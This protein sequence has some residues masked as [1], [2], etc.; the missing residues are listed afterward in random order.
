[1]RH[2]V[3]DNIGA[4]MPRGSQTTI[5]WIA[6]CAIAASGCGGVLA[7]AYEYDEMLV[8]ALDGSAVVD[9]NASVASL[10]VLRGIVLDLDEPPDLGRVRAFFETDGVTVSRIETSQRAG[11]TFVHVRVEVDDLPKLSRV[12]ALSWSLYRVTAQDEG[13]SYRQIVGLPSP[14]AKVAATAVGW[15]GDERVAFRLRAPSVVVSHN[16]PSG[17]ARGNIVVWEQPLAVRLRGGTVDMRVELDDQPILGR[18]LTLF[19]TTIAAAG[20][21]FAIAVWWMVSRGRQFNRSR[22]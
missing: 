10:V 19:A 8:L 4:T 3:E 1:M 12:P 22:R 9:V 7:P 11:R 13:V 20:A 16:A 5:W 6:T 17:V 15:S 14:A 21:V 18:T 2:G